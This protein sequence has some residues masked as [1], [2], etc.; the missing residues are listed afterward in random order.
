MQP[1]SSPHVPNTPDHNGCDWEPRGGA[2]SRVLPAALGAGGCGQTHL[3][4]GGLS[5]VP[6][7]GDG[8]GGVSLGQPLTPPPCSPAGPAA[9]AG[10][11]TSAGD[12]P[13]LKGLGG[14][15]CATPEP[16]GTCDWNQ[17]QQHLHKPHVPG[18]GSGLPAPLGS[19]L[20][21]GRVRR[22]PRFPPQKIPLLR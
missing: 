13:H 18:G 15:P 7:G 4:Q 14:A 11:G 22:V 17:T 6:G 16:D 9:S 19:P 1:W 5:A 21:A 3:R 20:A 8:I 2:T 10:T 12:P